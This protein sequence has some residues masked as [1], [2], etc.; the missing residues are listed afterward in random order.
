MGTSPQWSG[1]E[2][3][4]QEKLA[5]PHIP[6]LHGW[7]WEGWVAALRLPRCNMEDHDAVEEEEETWCTWASQVLTGSTRACLYWEKGPHL[8]PVPQQCIWEGW[9]PA[10]R[11]LRC[12]AEDYG[13]AEEVEA[14]SATGW[15]WWIDY[16]LSISINLSS[17]HIYIYI[18]I[19]IYKPTYR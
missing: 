2:Q 8:I 16:H 12:Y 1:G 5:M 15:L 4:R 9:V 18:Y 13:A 17:I 19:Y 3:W 11:L 7:I 10:L 6:G 14:T